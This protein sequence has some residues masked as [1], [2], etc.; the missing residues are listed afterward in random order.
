MKILQMRLLILVFL[1]FATIADLQ[2]SYGQGI[3]TT[4][5]LLKRFGRAHSRVSVREV[6]SFLYNLNY[7]VKIDGKYGP[8]TARAI[9]NF[10]GNNGMPSTGRVTSNL[11]ERLRG[12]RNFPDTW[13]AIAYTAEGMAMSGWNYRS[14]AEVENAVRRRLRRR[15]RSRIVIVRGHGEQCMSIAF[16]KTRRFY[17]HLSMAGM[18]IDK[19]EAELLKNCRQ[20]YGVRCQIRQTICANGRHDPSSAARVARNPNKSNASADKKRLDNEIDDLEREIK[21]LQQ[22]VR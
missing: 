21:E 19:V 1:F 14:R 3:L 7:D 13:G 6:Q 17:G 15:T 2:Q 20:R 4:E 11:V 16:Y 8:Q 9:R 18:T 10:E 22:K 5:E 12:G